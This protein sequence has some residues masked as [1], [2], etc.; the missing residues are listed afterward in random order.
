MTMPTKKPLILR[1]LPLIILLGTILVIV[2]MLSS[3]PKSKRYG[4]AKQAQLVVDVKNIKAS[5]YS[6]KI[7]SYGIVQPRTQ[8]MLVAQV[9]GEISYISDSL[10]DGGFFE[11]DQILLRIDAR[12]YNAEVKIAEASLLSA[13]QA[14]VE[15][16]ARS[17]QALADWERLGSGGKPG[18]LVLRKPQLASQQ[19]NVLSAQAN[20]EK[21]KLSL[22]RTEIVAPFSGRV[23]NKKVDIGQVVSN[24]AQLAEIFATDTVEIRLPINN[25]DLAF[26]DLPEV[27]QTGEKTN[28][29]SVVKFSSDLIG[30]QNW[31]GKLVR[32]EGAINNISQ[33]L[34]V[35]AQI[36]SPY[37]SPVSG[38]NPIK[39]GQYVSATIQGLE[40]NNALVIPNNAIYQGSYVYVLNDASELLRK[41]I[42][43]AWQGETESLV[44]SGLSNEER[45]VITPLGQVSSGTQVAILGEEKR[46]PQGR[47]GAEQSN[48]K[49][50]KVAEQRK[51][52]KQEKSS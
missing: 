5:P 52:V 15:E 22:E 9:S 18:D 44:A 17:K 33:Q 40:V 23:L 1:F 41:D 43:L 2:V 14:L 10:R 21:A 20:L 51:P 4:G 42:E 19:A 29:N 49:Q 31:Q 3:S 16:Q 25:K 46:Q 37:S 8:S 48:Q 6:I 38:Q 50:Q 27:Y 32:T 45:L 13:Q 47:P 35:V 36:D 11:K 30:S 7:E 39:I 34:Y 24:N 28:Q 12:D 26:I